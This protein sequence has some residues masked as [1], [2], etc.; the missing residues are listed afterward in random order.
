ML[1]WR[2]GPN[3]WFGVPLPWTLADSYIWN[4]SWRLA[5]RLLMVMGVTALISWR[6]FFISSAHLV[7]LSCL[8]TALLYRWKYGTWRF[9]KDQ[10]W[11]DY[12]P[13]ARC[14]H[15]GHFHKLAS[16][17]QLAQAHCPECG[18]GLKRISWPKSIAGE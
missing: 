18:G 17:E 14:R 2:P 3:P 9:W 16:A 7:G 5:S 15:C 1:F 4:K 12:R 13:V 8:Y 10:G 11:I 6:A